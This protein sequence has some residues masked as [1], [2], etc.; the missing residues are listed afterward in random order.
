MV[1][2]IFAV[3]VTVNSVSTKFLDC[4]T[5]SADAVKALQTNNAFLCVMGP[6]NDTALSW[7]GVIALLYAGCC[8]C[9]SS[10]VWSAVISAHVVLQL[11]FILLN[12]CLAP[13]EPAADAPKTEQDGIPYT[14]MP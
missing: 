5:F 9:I 10:L 7:L 11:V 12:T 14:A 1:A 6:N 4:K 13:S 3:T 2:S 8:L